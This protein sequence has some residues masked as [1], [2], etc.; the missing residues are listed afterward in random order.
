MAARRGAAIV[1]AGRLAVEALQHREDERGGLAGA[2]LGAGEQVATGEDERDGRGLDGGGLGVALV[3][4]GAKELGRQ[5]EMI[6]GHAG[7]PG[8]A[9]PHGAGPGQGAEVDR[10]RR[11]GNRGADRSAHRTRENEESTRD[12]RMA[13]A[14]RDRREGAPRVSPR[15]RPAPGRWCGPGGCARPPCGP[16]RPGRPTRRASRSPRARRRRGPSRGS[17]RAARRPGPRGRGG[18][19]G[20]WS[21]TLVRT[22]GASPGGKAGALG[23]VRLTG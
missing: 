16:W 9:L 4:D 1:G 10:D 5:P 13:P 19:S 22:I 23:G 2:G 21:T 17:G 18:R 8:G 15:P 3:R 7:A 20:R 12:R 11:R 14:M 6:E